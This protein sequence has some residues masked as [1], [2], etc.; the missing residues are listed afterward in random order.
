MRFSNDCM[1]E[2]TGKGLPTCLLTRPAHQSAG[3]RKALQQDG[4]GVIEFP[5]IAITGV[6]ADGF[7]NDLARNIAKFDIALFV[8]RN[9]VEQAFSYLDGSALPANLQL[10]VIGKGSMTA[11]REQ[12]VETR[13]IP[14]TTYNSEG[15]LE[16][17]VLQQVQGKSIIIFRGQ[18]GR[19]LLGDTL[20]ERGA[21][22]RYCEVYQR[23]LPAYPEGHFNKLMQ[24]GFADIAVF[25]SSE[26]LKNCFSLVDSLQT[27]KLQSIPWLLISERM[28]ETARELGH[29]EAIYI[30]KK[31]CDEGIQET[32]RQWQ[33]SRQSLL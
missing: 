28:R 24:N 15:L 8:S 21:R 31:A 11:L 33:E 20:L 25:T 30:A 22:V 2:K 16:T 17:A 6:A 18:E 4:F 12:G 14:S 5:T 3:L 13:L 23:V 9:A 27:K 10:G 29:N 19:N 32:L 26:G 7:L 1:T